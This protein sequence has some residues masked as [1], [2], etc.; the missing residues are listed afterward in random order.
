MRQ[1]IT[2]LLSLCFGLFL[3]DAMVS[4]LD[5][6]LILLFDIRVLEGLRGIV[7]VFTVLVGLLTYGLMGFAPMIPK[8]VFLPVTLFNPI[9]GFLVI[10]F[11]IYWPRRM[12]QVSWASSLCQVALGLSV[13][14][15]FQGGLKLRWPLVPSDHLRPRRFSWLNLSTFLLVNVFILLPALLAYLGLCAGVAVNHFS[16]GFVALHPEGFTV[17]VRKYVRSDGKSIQLVPMSHVGEA[18]FYRSLSQSFPTNSTILMEG[19]TD[20]NDLLT[21]RITYK[22]MAASLGLAPQEKEFKPSPVQ[23]IR[24]D[25]DVAQFTT[26]T[27]S[28]L[29]VVMLFHSK[30]LTPENLLKM[31]QYSPPPHFEEELFDD[32]LKKRNRRLLQEIHAQL[33]QS[34]SLIVPWG[35]AHMP[36]L[37]RE[38]QKLGFRLDS[39]REQIAIR[40]RSFLR[41]GRIARQHEA[42]RR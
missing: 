41:Q 34:D 35:A 37:A 39:T 12:Q 36:E 29:N 32:L 20:D 17:Q 24:A 22:R 9:A 31:M 18:D 19:V 7:F 28:F 15:F 27:I 11:L 38:I 10:P 5:D 33:S 23:T 13:L 4:L 3:A 8:R 42:E 30:G 21:N 26:N 40:F 14:V 25:V 2:I 16:E 1:P 6:S